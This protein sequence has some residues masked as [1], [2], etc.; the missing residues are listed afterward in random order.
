MRSNRRRWSLFLLCT[1]LPLAAAA[2]VP[3]TGVWDAPSR[4]FPGQYFE[5]KAHF[6][7]KNRDYRA[8]LQMFELSGFW[9]DKVSQYNAGIMYFSGIGVP[10][11]RV[12]GTAW[13]AIAAEAHDDLADQALQVAYASLSADEKRA[14]DAEFRTL[15]KK[16]GDAVS[17]PRA[18]AQY[19]KDANVSIF[20]IGDGGFGTSQTCFG[21]AGC[22][23]ENGSD[24]ERRMLA[25]RDA[26]VR[27]ITGHVTVGQVAPL[28]VDAAVKPAAAPEIPLAAPAAPNPPTP[29]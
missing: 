27:H 18:L 24:F 11:D 3:G 9:A 13:L 7:L 16:Y 17:V 26:L 10:P 4:L 12:K 2:D 20:R 25:E 29:R 22:V 21:P 15:D 1:L 8:A 19:A 28:A 14:A 5:Q 6:Y 23:E